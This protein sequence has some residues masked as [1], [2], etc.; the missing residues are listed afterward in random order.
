MKHTMRLVAKGFWGIPE[1]PAFT[2]EL[3]AQTGVRRGSVL[4]GGATGVRRLRVG[5]DGEADDTSAVILDY[6]LNFPD[7]LNVKSAWT[8]LAGSTYFEEVPK[9]PRGG[10]ALLFA[11][12]VANSAGRFQ[13]SN[14]VG[15][16]ESFTV[17]AFVYNLPDGQADK[18]FTLE[19]PNWKLRLND[20]QWEYQMVG[21]TVWES[22][23]MGGS[24]R[25]SW[26]NNWFTLTFLPEP[27]GNWN[28][29][30]EG[31]DE[32]T[33]SVHEVLESRAPGIIWN[34]GNF[35]IG[36][37]GG[38]FMWQ[39]GYPQF[40]AS[41][42]LRTGSYSTGYWTD[43]MGNAVLGGQYDT[44]LSGTSVTVSNDILDSL[45]AEVKAT[46]ATSN[47]RH[48]PFL[49]RVSATIPAGARNGT[50][51]VTWDSDD[52]PDAI[53]DIEPRFEGNA[54]EWTRR[55]GYNVSLADVQGEL[56]L[57]GMRYEALENRLVDIYIDGVRVLKNGIVRKSTRTDLMQT[58]ENLT[59]N[60]VMAPDTVVMLEID[61]MWAL[62][63][64]DLMQDD[65]IGDGMRLGPYIRLI[66]KNGG[67]RDSGMSGVPDGSYGSEAGPIL[68]TA[69]LGEAPAVRPSRDTPRGDFLRYLVETHGMGWGLSINDGV[70]T[71]GARN[72]TIQADFSSS[73]TRFDPDTTPG[74]Y[75]MLNPIDRIHDSGEVFNSFRVE[76]AED[77][78]GNPIVREWENA[79]SILASGGS[80]SKRFIGRRKRL[81]TVSDNSL[82]TAQDVARAVRSIAT[83]KGKPARYITF[84]T[85]YLN[86]LFI[87]AYVTADGVLCEVANIGGSVAR[88]EMNLTLQEAA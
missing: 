84:E 46:L 36:T 59:H 48:T 44:S 61:D 29:I 65:P 63:D 79:D 58:T 27:R 88:D 24:G 69:A 28:L 16:N 42:V 66:L 9:A 33:I 19:W 74:R 81:A 71:L 64:E 72:T 76:G 87:G 70:W 2:L 15:L 82:R 22:L 68:P 83:V 43:H 57:P 12:H 53:L 3:S 21:D 17:R 11:R 85:C 40:G 49:Y 39:V 10:K 38:A 20:G 75:A 67:V 77:A 30:I 60:Q 34:A 37:N 41:G 50:E 18:F 86:H 80:G 1:P 26:Y 6:S 23:N 4:R 14:L 54:D 55:N 52:H 5:S 32:V 31:G 78:N 51:T 56:L 62:M 8:A 47:N 73:A 13:I 45:N 35:I 7:A 25:D